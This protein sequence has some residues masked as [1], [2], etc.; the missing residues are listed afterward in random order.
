VDA[1]HGHAVLGKSVGTGFSVSDAA[2]STVLNG[3]DVARDVHGFLTNFYTIFGSNDEALTATTDWSR[4]QLYLFG[5]SY[6]GMYVPSVAHYIYE[7]NQALERSKKKKKQHSVDSAEEQQH[8][9]HM[10][11]A[12]IALGNG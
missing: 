12:G 4:K 11:L 5:D 10:T 9:V 2:G 3:T 6:A 8:S 1:R 7:Q